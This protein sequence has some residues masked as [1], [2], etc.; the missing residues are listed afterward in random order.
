MT[1]YSKTLLLLVMLLLLSLLIHLDRT[2]V[3]AIK[4]VI[5]EDVKDVDEFGIPLK[6]FD[7]D[8]ASPLKDVTSPLDDAYYSPAKADDHWPATE[9]ISKKTFDDG[10]KRMPF[11]RFNKNLYRLILLDSMPSSAANA[12]QDQPTSSTEKPKKKKPSSISNKRDGCILQKLLRNK[13]TWILG[14]GGFGVYKI[15]ENVIL[16]FFKG[17]SSRSPSKPYPS[18]NAFTSKAPWYS[19][20]HFVRNILILLLFLTLAIILYTAVRQFGLKGAW[21]G[22]NEEDADDEEEEDNSEEDLP[23]TGI[24]PTV[25]GIKNKRIKGHHK[26]KGNGNRRAA[27]IPTCHHEGLRIYG[28][29]SRYPP[30][31]ITPSKMKPK[32]SFQANSPSSAITNS[33]SSLALGHPAAVKTFRSKTLSGVD[34]FID[35]TDLQDAKSR[36][37][38]KK[39]VSSGLLASSPPSSLVYAFQ[40][41]SDYTSGS[42]AAA[43]GNVDSYKSENSNPPGATLSD[44]FNAATFSSNIQPD[45]ANETKNKKATSAGAHPPKLKP[46]IPPKTAKPEESESAKMDDYFP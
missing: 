39:T 14:G 31:T 23:T 6:N 22:E 43:G 10:E 20:V 18:K 28:D 27:V 40:P 9:T 7:V 19:G 42:A 44:A 4:S 30:Q 36:K 16:P 38:T 45:R 46:K 3:T 15:G 29:A 37:K 41:H 5:I 25:K 35:P 24:I 1:R 2:T 12:Q 8:D 32:L 11:F 34:R 33:S 13:Y 26:K 21:A 17:A